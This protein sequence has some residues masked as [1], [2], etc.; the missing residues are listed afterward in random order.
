MTQALSPI[1]GHQFG[2]DDSAIGRI[3]EIQARSTSPTRRAVVI[4]RSEFGA[5]QVVPLRAD[6]TIIQQR[7]WTGRYF[8]VAFAD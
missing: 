4:D 7:L 2:F 3:V 5:L 6:G 1:A 8:R